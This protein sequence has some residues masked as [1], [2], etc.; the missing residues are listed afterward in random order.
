MEM[1]RIGI[2]EYEDPLSE[3]NQNR[4]PE[5][6]RLTNATNELI[7]LRLLSG[8]LNVNME[9]G[10][11]FCDRK[12]YFFLPIQGAPRLTSKS[13]IES[14]NALLSSEG[15]SFLLTENKE[16]LRQYLNINRRNNSI[17]ELVLFEVSSFL[18][19]QKSSPT[20]A[21]VHLYRCLEYLSYSFPMVYAA[22]SKNYKG[23]FTD[24]KKF[25][26]GDTSGELMFFRKFLN[27]LFQDER[28]TILEFPFEMNIT[29][30]YPIQ[31]LKQE[32][33]VIYNDFLYDF[34]NDM[35][36]V[37]FKNMLTL[38]KNTRN[39]YFHLLIGQ[40]QANFSSNNY[41]IDEY[42]ACINPSLLNWLSM[43]ILK[44]SVFGFYSSL[45]GA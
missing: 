10:S 26:T 30:N 16:Q 37:P 8:H 13:I 27:T 35:L 9:H 42:F 28:E 34:E 41:D 32:L 23:S 14:I 33:A 25:M 4:L 36:K 12:N 17:Y 44:I 22:K 3:V 24:L 45:P 11:N 2:F 38:F 31:P 43:I 19:C 7:L 21:F 40:G 1:R 15:N 6:I 29:M 5:F 39:R 18:C 20:A